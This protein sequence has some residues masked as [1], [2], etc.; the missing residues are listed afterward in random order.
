VSL[1]RHVITDVSEDRDTYVGRRALI[2]TRNLTMHTAAAYR[3]PG[4]YH[5]ISRS[6]R[7]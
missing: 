3:R 6:A 7:P 1:S 2:V 5:G 4:T